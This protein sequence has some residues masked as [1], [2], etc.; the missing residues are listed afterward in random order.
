MPDNIFLDT[1]ILIYLYSE[2]EPKKRE[3]AMDCA[4]PSDIWTRRLSENREPTAE[5]L[6]LA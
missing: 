2:D 1:K 5:K 4:N 6:D 3:A